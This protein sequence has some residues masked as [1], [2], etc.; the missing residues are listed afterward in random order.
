[1]SNAT[2]TDEEIMAM[3]MEPAE[4]E[5]AEVAESDEAEFE[6]EALEAEGEDEAE[7]PDDEGE[8]A[9]DEVAAEPDK[10]TVRVDGEEIEVTRDEL[11]RGYSGQAK[12]Q[13]GMREVADVRKA[14]ESEAMTLQQQREA[15]FALVQDMQTRGVLQAPSAPD[16]ALA[17]RD[18]VG[19]V[20]A[21]AKYQTELAEY[22]TQQR[23]FEQLTA[24]QRATQ[25]AQEARQ[26]EEGVRKLVELIPDLGNSEKA[27][28]V[29][30]MIVRAGEAYG[31]TA[32]EIGSVMD[33][34]ALHIL[35]KAAQ[36]D[37]MQKAKA[38]VADKVA[39][40][41]PVLKSAAK[42]SSAPDAKRLA[43]RMKRAPTEDNAVAWLLNQR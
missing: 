9:P 1:M 32:D 22:M 20:R 23:H 34:R 12:I 4:A 10:F 38:K 42:P 35:Y 6:P 27:P 8:E 19:Y 28:E 33:P 41:Q 37:A 14:I 36:F 3:V 13:K 18:P 15:I 40:A 29:Q 17:E 39:K 26:R 24:Q 5:Q 31:Y 11:L 7:S 2:V 16:P 25:Q 30:R 43:E 21:N